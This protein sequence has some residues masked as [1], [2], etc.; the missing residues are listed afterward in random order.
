MASRA[1]SSLAVLFEL[2]RGSPQV[3]R[4]EL[5]RQSGLSKAT[6]SETIAGLLERGFLAEVGK[7]QPGR[8]RSQVVLELNTRS[9]LVLGA[10][11]TERACQVVLAD[12]RAAPVSV[13]ERPL[14]GTDPEHFVDALCE[15]VDELRADRPI[16]GLGVG[17][18]GLVNQGGRE[19]VV[20]VPYRWSHVPLSDMLEARLGLP[21]VI[22]NRAKAAALGEY[23]QTV[24]QDPT[25]C[26]HLAYVFIGAG[27]VSG[28]VVNGDLY[29]GSGGAAGELGHVTVVPNGPDCGCG[30]RGCLHMLASESAIIRSVRSKLRQRS[31]AVLGQGLTGQALGMLSLPD[32]VAA[33][34]AGDQIVLEAV[35]EAATY[36]GI[37][38]ANMV[39]LMNPSV[40]VI[41]G[42]VASFGDPLIDGIRAEVRQRALWDAL[43]GVRIVPSTLG[44]SAGTIGAAALFLNSFATETL[45]S[46]APASNLPAAHPRAG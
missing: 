32:L 38:I 23:W 3:T 37:A 33:A 20:S 7:R 35:S 17:V 29:V 42:P 5:V 34:A 16:L 11:F 19:V 15:C 44:D 10:Q 46:D 1:Q 2:L 45:L 12:L 22:A 28:L 25:G 21:V 39:N 27:I 13:V 43:D 31:P 14:A 8:G 24:H 30:N 18:P 4:T 41:G 9:R 40:V 26:D 6:V 36:L